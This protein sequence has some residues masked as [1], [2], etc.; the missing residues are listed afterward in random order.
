[1]EDFIELDIEI[2]QPNPLQPRGLITPES[3]MELVDSIR[4][5]G[6]L[7]PLL[8]AQTPAGYQ[9]V[10]GERRWRAAKLAGL[11]KIPVIIKQT[12]TRGMLEMALVEN[13]QRTDLNPIERAQ[14]F[15]RL[16][17]EFSLTNSEIA[18]RIGKSPSY[19]SNT[20]RLLTLPDALKDALISGATTEGH[21]R[22]IVAL[23]DPR[24]MVEAYKQVL[25]DGLSVR[26][27][28]DLTRKMKVQHKKIVGKPTN[29][30]VSEEIE[31][32]Q[33]QLTKSLAKV[34]PNK[35]K[36]RRSRVETKI[37]I[38]LKGNLE[39]TDGILRKIHQALVN[40]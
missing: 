23:E 13:V 30:V 32:M 25:K 5:H 3:L 29:I 12:T 33:D 17:A 9:I 35:V 38:I 36:L 31:S 1:M 2:L 18:Q 4:E 16:M 15:E 22:A 14:A 19:I 20:L 24:L 6:I 40:V 11:G 21:V 10:A 28:E 26:A 7:E 34:I 27:A 37:V 8:V 39:E